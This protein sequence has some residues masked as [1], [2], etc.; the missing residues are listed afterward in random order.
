MSKIHS[1]AIG[2][3]V[4]FRKSTDRVSGLKL[5]QGLKTIVC[6]ATVTSDG[7]MEYSIREGSWF[8]HNEFDFVHRAT[9]ATIRR[10]LK[11]EQE[12]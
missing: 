7:N 10:A 2:D 3:V 5:R 4:R 8:Q 9:P 12:T 1:F 6:A 11:Y